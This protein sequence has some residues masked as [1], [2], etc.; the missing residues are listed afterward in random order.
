MGY[1]ETFRKKPQQP[2]TKTCPDC[3]GSGKVTVGAG[4]PPSENKRMKNRAIK[5]PTCKGDKVVLR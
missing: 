1:G 3:N 5:C 4:G 2:R